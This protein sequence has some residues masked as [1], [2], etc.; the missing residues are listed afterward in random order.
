MG[1]DREEKLMK[2]MPSSPYRDLLTRKRWPLHVRYWMLVGVYIERKEE[3]KPY[4]DTIK[5]QKLKASI[6]RELKKLD[7]IDK[8]YD[9]W[10]SV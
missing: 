4:I 10:H 8:A 2:M 7:D 9:D 1:Y 3:R 6:E 5:D